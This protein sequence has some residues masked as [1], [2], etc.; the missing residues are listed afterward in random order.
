MPGRM[1]FRIIR[2]MYKGFDCVGIVLRTKD[3]L[4]EIDGPERWRYTNLVARALCTAVVGES[5]TK[6][7]SVTN[8]ACCRRLLRLR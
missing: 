6:C 4:S 3:R 2:M 7:V 8:T 5:G 1:A